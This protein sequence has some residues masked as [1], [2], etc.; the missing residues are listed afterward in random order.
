MKIKHIQSRE[1]CEQKQF[2]VQYNRDDASNKKNN[3]IMA[4]NNKIK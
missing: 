4:L 2:V 1:I 3:E